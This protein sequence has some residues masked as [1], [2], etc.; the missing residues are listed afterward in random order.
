MMSEMMDDVDVAELTSI[1]C[2]LNEDAKA[3]YSD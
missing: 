3:C 1:I 2:S